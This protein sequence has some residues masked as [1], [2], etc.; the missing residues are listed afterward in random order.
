MEKGL[1]EHIAKTCSE[2][3]AIQEPKGTLGYVG[4]Y[5]KQL[6][7]ITLDKKPNNLIGKLNK[8]AEQTLILCGHLDVFPPKNRKEWKYDPFSGKILDYNEDAVVFGCGAADMKGG[9]TALLEVLNLLAQKDLGINILTIFTTD[10][11]SGWYK[12]TRKLLET[13]PSAIGC[14]IPEA[15]G[16]KHFSLGE[17]GELMVVV[18]N[19]EKN[20]IKK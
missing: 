18:S 3:V 19:K 7:E 6:P 5:L 10:E 1:K 12:G 13:H 2:L 11:E 20:K 17:K 14:F 16:L 9:V 4:D 15:T 8:D